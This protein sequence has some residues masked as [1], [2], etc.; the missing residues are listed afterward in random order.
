MPSRGLGAARLILTRPRDRVHVGSRVT[1]L[2]KPRVDLARRALSPARVENS[3]AANGWKAPGY[4]GHRATHGRSSY[5]APLFPKKKRSNPKRINKR[6]AANKKS[7][8][9]KAVEK[10]TFAKKAS[11][12]KSFQKSCEEKEDQEKVEALAERGS[13]IPPVATDA[14]LSL[15]SFVVGLPK[16]PALSNAGLTSLIKSPSNPCGSSQ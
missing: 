16:G 1:A 14:V 5:P 9:K 6:V 7:P 11:C 8:A 4:E 10:K 2:Q 15:S 12:E 3:F 13:I